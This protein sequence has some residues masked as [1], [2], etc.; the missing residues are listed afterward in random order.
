MRT[1]IDLPHDY[2]S[3]IAPP[4]LPNKLFD[5]EMSVLSTGLRVVSLD[6]Y[7]PI[8]SIGLFIKAGPRYD[9]FYP[10]GTS[11]LLS[12]LAFSGTSQYQNREH[13]MAALEV[14]GAVTEC[15]MEREE[16]IY[17]LMGYKNQVELMAEVLS[18]VVFR[19]R[20][21]EEEIEKARVMVTHD[22]MNFSMRPD[23]EPFLTD[24][25]YS[26][27]YKLN[28]LG[29]PSVCPKDSIPSIKR[30]HLMWYLA[31]HF[32]PSRMVLTGLGVEHVALLEIAERHF[33]KPQVSWDEAKYE[34]DNSIAQYTGSEVRIERTNPPVV[35]P[36]P[37]PNLA[38][39][40]ITT[41]CVSYEDP[42]FFA[43]AVL[44]IMMG[45]G[46]SFSAGGPG[47]GMY[48]RL[49]ANV[50]NYHHFVYSAQS[51]LHIH[52]DTGIYSLYGS[53]PHEHS[54]KLCQVLVDELKRLSLLPGHEELSRAKKMLQSNMLMNLE[55]HMILFEDLGRQVLVHKRYHNAR[56]LYDR[57]EKVKAADI[58]AAGQRLLKSK[59]SMAAVGRLEFIP[60]LKE[61][62]EVFVD[63][64]KRL[65]IPGRG[66]VS[67]FS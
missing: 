43:F 46:S 61:M 10:P 2:I 65:H 60:T 51:T 24:Y 9:V 40:S 56:E 48:S 27:A 45:G 44:D 37:L 64:K 3:Q 54:R 29:N 58:Q 66:N 22:L 1:P 32:R 33:E 21:T 53:T 39:F 4:V 35:G 36:N 62:E 55:S 42:L 31:A 67:L 28:T 30:D 47:K 34:P 5:P 12:K 13:I 11:H 38:Y 52:G 15:R 14:A 6:C 7:G 57:L 17:K 50:M 26:S 16:M 23:M 49:Y 20:I 59:L 19:P 63:S 18:E 25:T 8:S 41:E